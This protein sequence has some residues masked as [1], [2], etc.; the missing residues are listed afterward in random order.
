MSAATERITVTYP[1]HFS[2]KQVEQLRSAVAMSYP[3]FLLIPFGDRI[4]FG[5]TPDRSPLPPK[6]TRCRYCTSILRADRCGSC[7]APA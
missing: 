5:H 2:G 1:V 3:T 6:K 7:G 4:E